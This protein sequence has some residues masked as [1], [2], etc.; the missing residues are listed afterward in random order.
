MSST[1]LHIH[2]PIPHP[3]SWFLSTDQEPPPGFMRLAGC[4]ITPRSRSH[5]PT[6]LVPAGDG[7]PS[8]LERLL[9]IA[10]VLA[11]ATL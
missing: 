9:K 10:E 2:G 5:A 11:G 6:D 1:R 8:Q 7:L 3:S 4:S